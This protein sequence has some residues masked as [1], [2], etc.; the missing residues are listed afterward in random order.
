MPM[1]EQRPWRPQP[2]DTQHAGACD[3]AHPYGRHST[4]GVE[5]V[6]H[7]CQLCSI[8][9]RMMI[10]HNPVPKRSQK[11]IVLNEN[12]LSSDANDGRLFWRKKGWRGPWS[13]AM[14]ITGC[15]GWCSAQPPAVWHQ[16]F[17]DQTMTWQLATRR[18]LKRLWVDLAPRELPLD[19]GEWLSTGEKHNFFSFFFNFLN[20]FCFFFLTS[21]TF[22]TGELLFCFQL[23]WPM[24]MANDDAATASLN[25]LWTSWT[26]STLP[27]SLL[28]MGFAQAIAK[29]YVLDARVPGSRTRCR[30]GPPVL[31]RID[32]GNEWPLN[33]ASKF[34]FK[35]EINLKWMTISWGRREER[36]MNSLEGTCSK[37]PP[38]R[39][40]VERRSSSAPEERWTTCLPLLQSLCGRDEPQVPWYVLRRGEVREENKE[41]WDV[42]ATAIVLDASATWRCIE[43]GRKAHKDVDLSDLLANDWPMIYNGGHEET[44]SKTGYMAAYQLHSRLPT[45]TGNEDTL[46]LCCNKAWGG[47]RRMTYPLVGLSSV[48]GVEAYQ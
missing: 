33:K 30:E 9:T 7:S 8:C 29:M 2:T 39:T 48:L 22:W 44:P 31:R 1:F 25:V 20:F 17:D 28:H 40:K 23:L 32:G 42:L 38:L 46:G 12:D 41:S 3:Q 4:N 15:K 16:K 36:G 21:L 18:L 24:T 35:V 11:Q 14:L 10:P 26:N 45:T 19:W 6:F 43:E 13:W 47:G 34:S 5:H 27:V 37:S